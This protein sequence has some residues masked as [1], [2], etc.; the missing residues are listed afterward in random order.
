MSFFVTMSTQTPNEYRERIKSLYV[1]P[2]S[3][4]GSKG[5][6]GVGITF[7]N[8]IIV[9]VKRDPKYVTKAEIKVLAK[10]YGKSEEEITALFTDKKRKI[11]VREK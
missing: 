3:A 8:R 7:G 5:V 1:E 11:E 9:R 4:S 10:E 6:A 2:V